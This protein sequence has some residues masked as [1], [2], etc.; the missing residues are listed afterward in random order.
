[1]PEIAV[2]FELKVQ[3]L[4]SSLF[5]HEF[6]PE[7]GEAIEPGSRVARALREQI[8]ERL[9]AQIPR[10]GRPQVSGTH[11]LASF[12]FDGTLRFIIENI[13]IIAAN[14]L[15]VGSYDRIIREIALSIDATFQRA[16]S[17]AVVAVGPSEEKISQNA[18]DSLPQ[19]TRTFSPR[20]IGILLN[21]DVGETTSI[22]VQASIP[23]SEENSDTSKHILPTGGKPWLTAVLILA[24]AVL[25]AIM[26][27]DRSR[28][29]EDRIL[30]ALENARSEPVQLHN[31]VI[32]NVPPRDAPLLLEKPSAVG[33]SEH[34]ECIRI[35]RN[36]QEVACE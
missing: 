3:L 32:V 36:G 23:P 1:M 24:V 34:Q 6:D 29:S 25:F 30:Q 31:E 9:Y 35:I 33:D 4:D 22:G 28:K 18:E 27:D 19:I 20:D 26:Q 16:W 13:D 10:L 12:D 8:A 7:T 14:A 21:L 2:P 15:V 11:Q 17:R 5:G